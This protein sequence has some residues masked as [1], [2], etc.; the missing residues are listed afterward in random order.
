MLT[1]MACLSVDGETM[2]PR[3]FV[4]QNAVLLEAIASCEK[5]YR[6][7]LIEIWM[8]RF[9]NYM[10]GKVGMHSCRPRSSFEQV[11]CGISRLQEEW[12]E[13]NYPLRCAARCALAFD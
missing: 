6:H 8:Q 5:E 10:K 7:L 2:M 9:H 11:A 3:C 4:T 1:S 13:T 12:C